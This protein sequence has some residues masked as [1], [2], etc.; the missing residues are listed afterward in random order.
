MSIHLSI[1]Q[2]IR[3]CICPSISPYVYPS[4]HPSVRPSIHLSI[5]PSVYPSVYQPVRLSIRPS[6]SPFVYPSVYHQSVSFICLSIIHSSLTRISPP[7]AMLVDD[8][9]SSDISAAAGCLAVATGWRDE[10]R[11]S[12]SSGSLVET[13]DEKLKMERQPLQPTLDCTG[14][15][16]RQQTLF[17]FICMRLCL[18]ARVCLCMCVCMSVFFA[19]C[20]II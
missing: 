17:C 5:S 7:C 11:C 12:D 19:R 1:H 10:R 20:C 8:I 16:V 13:G 4:V 9:G 18:T 2:F 6:I 15:V 14:R 3:L